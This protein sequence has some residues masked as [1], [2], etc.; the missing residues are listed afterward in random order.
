[1]KQIRLFVV[2]ALCFFAPGIAS[3]AFITNAPSADTDVG[4]S[5]VWELGAFKNY[6]INDGAS[7]ILYSGDSNTYTLQIGAKSVAPGSY[8]VDAYISADD[9]GGV[10]DSRYSISISV[11]SSKGSD[12]RTYSGLEHGDVYGGRFRNWK[13]ISIPVKIGRPSFIS[14]TILN[15]SNLSKADW[16]AIDRFELRP[17]PE[18]A[19]SGVPL[20]EP[21]VDKARPPEWLRATQHKAEIQRQQE[22]ERRRQ[23]E[24]RHARCD[25]LYVGKVVDAPTQSWLFGSGNEKALVLGFSS[26]NGVATVR[27]VNNS[28]MVGEVPCWSLK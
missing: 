7:D 2:V 25:H 6:G 15:S 14:I 5:L 20:Y 17:A 22:D 19:S 11:N 28:N 23:E 13:K 10:S 3:A 21:P 8:N 24:A 18:N 12:Q 9:H 26:S 16:V 1:M 27:S 4:N